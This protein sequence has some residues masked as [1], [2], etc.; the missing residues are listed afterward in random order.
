MSLVFLGT[1]RRSRLT[2]LMASRRIS[3]TL[4]M[5]ASRGARGNAATNMVLQEQSG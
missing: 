1:S 4:L 2:I 3:K 5:R